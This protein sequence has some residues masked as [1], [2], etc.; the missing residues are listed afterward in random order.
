MTQTAMRTLKFWVRPFGWANNRLVTLYGDGSIGFIA[1]AGQCDDCPICVSRIQS[2]QCML[3]LAGAEFTRS[4]GQFIIWGFP[5][6]GDPT[7]EKVSKWLG[8]VIGER[9]VLK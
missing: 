1:T 5:N 7:P 2:V 6:D 4:G 3:R 9:L 8:S